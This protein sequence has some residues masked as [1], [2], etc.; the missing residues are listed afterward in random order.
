MVRFRVGPGHG[1][2]VITAGAHSWSVNLDRRRRGTAKVYVH[3]TR[4][5]LTFTVASRDKT[6]PPRGGLRRARTGRAVHLMTGRFVDRAGA[7]DPDLACL[8]RPRKVAITDAGWSSSVARWAHNPEVAGS[9]PA[10]ATRETAGQRPI[11]QL[12]EWASDVS[13]TDPLPRLAA[14]IIVCGSASCLARPGQGARRLRHPERPPGPTSQE[15]PARGPVTAPAGCKPP[16]EQGWSTG[17]RTL[18]GVSRGSPREGPTVT[19]RD[20]TGS[21]RSPRGRFGLGGARLSRPMTTR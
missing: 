18:T 19:R 15:S 4:G 13:V 1:R 7:P 12:V 21:K 3:G 14:K 16:T 6:R 8:R 11:N 9:H 17:Y 20:V 5:P 2:T 10:P